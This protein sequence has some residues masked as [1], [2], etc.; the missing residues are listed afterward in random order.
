MILQVT[1]EIVESYLRCRRKG[2]LKLQGENGDKSEYDLLLTEVRNEMETV[3]P[4]RL[5]NQLTVGESPGVVLLT[6]QLMR[7]GVET[8]CNCVIEDAF[9]SLSVDA[10]KR[11]PG[12]SELGAFHYVPVVCCPEERIRRLSISLL[13][14]YALLLGRLQ[15]HCPGTGYVVFGRDCRMTRLRLTARMR[16][17]AQP[18]LDD[19][20][21]LRLP[22]SEIGPLFLGDHCST[23]EFRQRCLAQA[24]QEDSLTLLGM[25]DVEVKKHNQ[26]GFFT[27]TPTFPHVSTQEASEK[28]RR[29]APITLRPS[30]ICNPKQ[31]TYLL[32]LP[33]LPICRVHVYFDVQAEIRTVT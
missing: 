26:K 27:I 24:R 11:V 33:P 5:H 23:C 16:E 29:R 4:A 21:A 22:N 25:A 2:Y 6:P 9:L 28:N 3:L 13:Q 30:G 14:V 7:R 8:L 19:L 18:L 17:K 20:K 10:L 1:R 32:N 12:D 31:K 15:G